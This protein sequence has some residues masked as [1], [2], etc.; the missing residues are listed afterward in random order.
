MKYCIPIKRANYSFSP[1][2]FLFLILWV[3]GKWF[4]Q[5][6]NVILIHAIQKTNYFTITTNFEY[7]DLD[8]Q[9]PVQS[10]F[11]DWKAADVFTD[12]IPTL[13]LYTHMYQI[14][15][16]VVARLSNHHQGLTVK[17][18]LLF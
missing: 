5:Y 3:S 11:S 7:A 15:C 17:T 9:M 18:K 8:N 16:S 2:R 12:A 14:T 13:L 6:N 4:E 10:N 1:C